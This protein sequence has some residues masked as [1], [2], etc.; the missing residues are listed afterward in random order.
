MNCNCNSLKMNKAV[1]VS[2]VIFT[3]HFFASKRLESDIIAKKRR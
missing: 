2:S 1:F 3:P